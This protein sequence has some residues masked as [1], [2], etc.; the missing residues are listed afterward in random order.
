MED[1]KRQEE[2]ADWFMYPMEEGQAVFARP[3]SRSINLLDKYDAMG[4]LKM[5]AGHAGDVVRSSHCFF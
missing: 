4:I 3:K 5:M 2:Y 1:A